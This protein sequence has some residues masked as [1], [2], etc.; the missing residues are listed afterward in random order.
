MVYQLTGLQHTDDVNR[1]A[2]HVIG[3][4][5]AGSIAVEAIKQLYKA[6]RLANYNKRSCQALATRVLDIFNVA[7][8]SHTLLVQEGQWEHF[9][10]QL[11]NKLQEMQRFIDSFS[12]HGSTICVLYLTA[13]AWQSASTL[14]YAN[15]TSALLVNSQ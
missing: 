14:L 3:S 5:C 12:S 8:C 9:V 4:F 6:A 13:S 11:C 7:A 2:G 10:K 15:M 1:R